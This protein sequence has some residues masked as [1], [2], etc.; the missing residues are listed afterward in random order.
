VHG[1][2]LADPDFALIQRVLQFPSSV[3]DYRSGRDHRAFLT[4]L[5]ELQAPHDLESFTKELIGELPS[6]IL[7][8]AEPS[9]DEKM[10]AARLHAEKY[11]T[12]AW[13]FR[14]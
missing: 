9:Q 11:G 6:D 12:A 10:R 3:P 7:I 14:R 2:L 8:S 4:S 1:T 13:N 5:K